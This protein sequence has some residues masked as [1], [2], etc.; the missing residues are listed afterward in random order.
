MEIYRGI[1]DFTFESET[2]MTIGVFD[3]VHIGHQALIQ[4]TLQ[5]ARE[6]NR[7]CGVMTFD[8]HPVEV[9]APHVQL[10]YLTS[11]PERAQLIERLDVDFLCII[12][13]S[14]E[15]SRTSAADF[16]RPLFER[17]R[18]RE[19]MIGDDFTLG[20]NRQGDANF[21]RALGRAWGFK[22]EVVAPVHLDGEIVSST[23]I[24]ASLREGKVQAAT[25]MLGRRYGLSG[26]LTEDFNL[27]PDPK[28]QMPVDGLYA[29]VAREN[30]P[31]HLPISCAARILQNV[32]YLP[33]N[34]QTR[35]LAGKEIV[36]EFVKRL[37]TLPL[38][39]LPAS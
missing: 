35:Q 5:R 4:Q 26:Q 37:A 2:A 14:V 34:E 11:M 27:H 21:L 6:T 1:P 18:M 30:K 8:P 36:I 20:H 13:F 24:R 9:L 25:D 3:G 16:V 29:A 19:L 31:Q 22:L 17:L 32:V 15:T 7:L 33:G 38:Q 28:R 23:R 12:P 10:R 39:A